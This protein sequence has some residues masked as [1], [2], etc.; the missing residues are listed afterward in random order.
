MPINS[1]RS[2]GGSTTKTFVLPFILLILASASL[3]MLIDNNYALQT[4]ISDMVYPKNLSAYNYTAKVCVPPVGLKAED[5]DSTYLCA[6]TENMTSRIGCYR[7][8]GLEPSM[9]CEKDPYLENR[10]KCYNR[11]S[12]DEKNPDLCEMLWGDELKNCRSGCALNLMRPQECEVWGQD[13]YKRYICYGKAAAENLNTSICGKIPSGSDVKDE[14]GNNIRTDDLQE[15]CRAGYAIYTRNI[16]ACSQTTNHDILLYCKA[17]LTNESTLCQQ[18]ETDFHA[19][20]CI[21]DMES[22]KQMR[23]ESETNPLYPNRP[24]RIYFVIY[25]PEIFGKNDRIW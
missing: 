22:V 19:T 23:N 18:M 15:L 2:H 17:M 12:R 11:L 10:I 6:T 25:Y 5:Y 9:E 16:T 20:K 4:S 1:G 7:K 24:S 13:T 14:G 3:K 8:L 21:K